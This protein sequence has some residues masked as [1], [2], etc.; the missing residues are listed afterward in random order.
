MPCVRVDGEI[1][2]APEGVLPSDVDEGG[3]LGSCW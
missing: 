2:E 3:E 1:G